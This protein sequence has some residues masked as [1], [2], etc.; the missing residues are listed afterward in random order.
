MTFIEDIPDWCTKYGADQ[1]VEEL[2][3]FYNKYYSHFISNKFFDNMETN[4]SKSR[5]YGCI[6]ISSF[7]KSF[8]NVIVIGS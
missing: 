4:V 3:V 8:D 2:N 7:Y 6:V 1:L 5:S